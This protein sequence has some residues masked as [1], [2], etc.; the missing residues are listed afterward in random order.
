MLS[1]TIVSIFFRGK[2]FKVTFSSCFSNWLSHVF[3]GSKQTK[4]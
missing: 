1:I 2:V 4:Y 3:P